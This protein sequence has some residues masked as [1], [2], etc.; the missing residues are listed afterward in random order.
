MFRGTN[1]GVAQWQSSWFVIS[2]LLV[3]LRSPAPYGGFPERPKGADCKSVVTDFG[4]PNPPSPTKKDVSFWY[5]LFINYGVMV[6]HHATCLRV[7]HQKERENRS[8]L[9]II[10]L[11]LCIK[12]RNDDI[13]CSAL[14]IC[15][16]SCWWYAIPAEL[17][18][19]KALP[20]L[21]CFK[22]YVHSK[23]LCNLH[24]LCLDYL[25]LK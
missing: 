8:F 15:N 21:F 17:M 1:A 5:V 14:M 16:T 9:H 6:Y 3:R 10:T 4:G 7:Y 18:I 12:L 24:R 25:D 13:Q 11:L 22:I 23:L 20:W 19:Y 2:R